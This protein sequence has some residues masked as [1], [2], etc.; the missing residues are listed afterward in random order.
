MVALRS[1]QAFSR[2]SHFVIERGAGEIEARHDF[3]VRAE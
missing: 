3:A 2:L 1:A